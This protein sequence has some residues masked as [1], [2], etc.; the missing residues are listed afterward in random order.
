MLVSLLKGI[1]IRLVSEKIVLELMV[2]LGDWAV[3][4]TTNQ[5]DDAIWSPVRK[6]LGAEE[7]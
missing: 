6:A 5:L 1:L 2:H 4:R 3:P 7:K